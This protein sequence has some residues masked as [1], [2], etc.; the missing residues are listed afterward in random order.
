[1]QV[2]LDLDR[3]LTYRNSQDS[4]NNCSNENIMIGLCNIDTVSELLNY[5]DRN[6][7][8]LIDEYGK[9][10]LKTNVC[11]NDNVTKSQNMYRY[12][13]AMQCNEVNKVNFSDRL[14]IDTNHNTF[15][16]TVI[17]NVSL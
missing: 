12:S 16:K 14:Y 9:Q 2:M 6:D 5:K 15:T 10:L 11:H 3:H 13:N 4:R 17:S 1:M 7:N 8:K